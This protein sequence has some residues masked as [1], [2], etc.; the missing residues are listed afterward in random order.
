MWALEPQSPQPTVFT[1]RFPPPPLPFQAEPWVHLRPRVD[2]EGAHFI[3]F[4]A[5]G[6]EGGVVVVQLSLPAQEVL[7]LIDGQPRVAVV[8]QAQGTGSNQQVPGWKPRSFCWP[9]CPNP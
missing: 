2:V 1:G 5:H 9:P 7:L 8:L 6:L 4:P 3:A